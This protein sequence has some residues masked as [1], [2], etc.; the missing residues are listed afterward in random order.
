MFYAQGQ[1]GPEGPSGPRGPPGP[2]VCNIKALGFFLFNVLF[3]V[4]SSPF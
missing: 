3:C 1:P 2:M 4:W